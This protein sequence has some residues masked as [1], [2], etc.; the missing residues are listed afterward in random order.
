MAVGRRKLESQ[1]QL[2]LVPRRTNR[3]TPAARAPSPPRRLLP[4]AVR[5]R[6]R[7][8]RQSA[9]HRLALCRL[10][11]AGTLS[12]TR[13][14]RGPPRP[15]LADRTY[16]PEREQ[17]KRWDDK[18]DEQRILV[19]NNRKR[20]ARRKG[21]DLQRRRSEVV[22]RSFA[23]CCETGGGRR[24]WLRGMAEVTKRYL[25]TVAAHNPDRILWHLFGTG[26]PRAMAAGS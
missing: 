21:K 12:G 10:L 14:R 11:L 15:L 1:Q 2:F 5:R 25:M 3:T 8:D 23:H 13:F 17:R 9:R 20:V 16:I 18:K 19:R 26:K 22:E 7:G 24:S 6:L 4:H